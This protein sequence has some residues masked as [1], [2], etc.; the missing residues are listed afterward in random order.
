MSSMPDEA[1]SLTPAHAVMGFRRMRASDL[2]TVHRIELL[3]YAYP[4]TKGTFRDCI[5]PGYEAWLGVLAGDTVAYGILFS[6]ASEAHILNLCVHPD[7]RGLDLGRTLLRHMLERG[8]R[9]EARVTFLEVRPSNVIA[10]R[11]YQREGFRQ[12]G[13]RHGYY[14]GRDGREDALVL[15]RRLD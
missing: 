5:K 12:I 2:D 7:F 1:R 14:P 11:L 3:S 6:G 9:N 4:W 13:R 10:Q 15:A 8:A